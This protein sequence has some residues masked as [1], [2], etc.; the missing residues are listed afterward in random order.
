MGLR[1]MSQAK[2]ASKWDWKPK[3]QTKTLQNGPEGRKNPQDK[4]E[5][6]QSH[7]ECKIKL[8][9]RDQILGT[10]K[11][12]SKWAWQQELEVKQPHRP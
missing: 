6:L 12:A 7:R 3:R 9:N 5:T 4:Q 10:S 11:N 1:A 2:N 8:Q